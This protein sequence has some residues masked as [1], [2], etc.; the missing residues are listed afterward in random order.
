MPACAGTVG[1]CDFDFFRAKTG[2]MADLLK[3][4]ATF[5][6]VFIKDGAL[7]WPNGYDLG[8][9]LRCTLK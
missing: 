9:S 8:S 5:V 7:T 1:M 3:D 6:R 2:P 4:A